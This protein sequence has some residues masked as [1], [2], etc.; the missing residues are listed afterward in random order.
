MKKYTFTFIG[1][2]LLLALFASQTIPIS[3]IN[4][5]LIPV[6]PN[7]FNMTNQT[8]PQVDPNVFNMTNQTMP[9]VDPSIFDAPFN[10]NTTDNS[11]STGGNSDDTSFPTNTNTNMTSN[12]GITQVLTH[13]T[14]GLGA[15]V[16][17][18]I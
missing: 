6:D 15:L 13:F 12:G 1:L 11:T 4:T 10:D 9:Q 14:I 17:G 5:T 16:L 2:S 3:A 8:L 7:V 18:L